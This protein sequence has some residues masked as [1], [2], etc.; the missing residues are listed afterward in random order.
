MSKVG[1]SKT[2]ARSGRG[3]SV[4]VRVDVPNIADI[5]SGESCA[6]RLVTMGNEAVL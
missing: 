6:T 2:V 3:T 5:Y 4:F 1:E